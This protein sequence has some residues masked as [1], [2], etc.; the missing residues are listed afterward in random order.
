VAREDLLMMKPLEIK[1]LHLIHQAFEKK[2]SQR[3]AAELAGLSTRQMRRLMKRIHQGE[4]Y[5]VE[6]RVQAQPVTI[7]QRL[8][9]SLHLRHH[10]RSLRYREVPPARPRKAHVLL[11]KQKRFRPAADHPWRRSYQPTAATAN[12]SPP[13]T[14]FSRG[15]PSPPS[16]IP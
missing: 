11:P 3:Q 4:V 2:I 8:D 7:E 14:R 13:A 6:E 1:L 9:G 15:D 12:S 10:R 5:L 16:G